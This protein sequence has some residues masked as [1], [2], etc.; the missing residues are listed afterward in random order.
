MKA[1]LK[2]IRRNI[3]E[4]FGNSRYS[5]PA[6]FD[7]DRKLEIYFDFR[8]GFFIEVGANDGF[9]QSN[10][11]YLEKFLDWK[12]ILVEPIPDL[13]RA[14]KK[15]RKRSKVYNYAL[16]SNKFDET[17]VEMRY[18]NLRSLVTGALKSESQES[19][20][21]EEGL[22]TQNIRSSYMVKVPART[23]ESVLDD[24]GLT[25]DIDLFSLDVEGFELGVLEGLNLDKYR[26]KHIL[27]ESNFFAEVDL[28]LSSKYEVIN[29]LT[30]HDYLYRLKNS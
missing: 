11:Y 2:R 7:L 1:Y 5:R 6:L 18:A 26:P 16:V 19:R 29:Q 9:N 24:C 4:S 14:C 30:H 28:F 13:F 12:G 8:Q 3:Y 27:V 10:T 17:F 23:L 25:T 21:I 20:H 22:E 15:L